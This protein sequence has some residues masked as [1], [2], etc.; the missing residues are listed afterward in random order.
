MSS[1]RRSNQVTRSTHATHSTRLTHG[2]HSLERTTR[3]DLDALVARYD[4]IPAFEQHRLIQRH[5]EISEVREWWVA[6]PEPERRR[7]EHDA[8]LLIGNLDGLPWPARI[9]A[10]HITI[11]RIL[12]RF[13][14]PAALQPW[15][16]SGRRRLRMLRRTRPLPRRVRILERLKQLHSGPGYFDRGE[17]PRFLIAFNPFTAGIVE[18]LG[19]SIRDTDDPYEPPYAPGV[20]AVGLFVP[21]NESD[22]LQFEGKAH[23]MSEPVLLANNAAGGRVAGMIAWQ[24]GRFPHGPDAL[25]ST[26]VRELAPLLVRFGEALVRDESVRVTAFG[27]SFGGAVTGTALAQGLRVDQVV[28]LSSAGLGFG[29]RSV[30][31][32]PSHA[33]VP[34]VSFMCPGDTSVG[35]IQGM[36]MRIPCIGEVGHGGSPIYD[37][38]VTRLET[39]WLKAEAD[40]GPPL[41]GHTTILEKWGTTAKHNMAAVLA[42]GDVELAAPRSLPY[43]VAERLGLPLTP[44]TRPGYRPERREWPAP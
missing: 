31:D 26:R 7:M 43:R 2:S 27:F 11:D 16:P 5:P 4:R 36:R 23:T 18:Y 41:T 6:L 3:A 21:G 32:L 15:T 33:Q 44:I 1:P 40:G 24:G 14:D 35:W 42:G 20:R 39:G 8:A 30:A 25:L 19:P 17:L 37:P 10:N 34:H 12:A 13:A 9:R 29:T 38:G 22:L 28:H